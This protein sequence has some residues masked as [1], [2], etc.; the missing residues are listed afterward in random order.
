VTDSSQSASG[1]SRTDWG[2]VRRAGDPH[3]SRHGESL[4]SVA[5]RYW[6]VIY[7]FIRHSGRNDDEARELTQAFLAD[8]LLGRGLLAM[9]SPSRGRFR[10]L[11]LSA[12]ANFVRDDHRRRTAGHRPQASHRVPFAVP[13][14]MMA[15]AGA[16]PETAFTGAWVA[17]LVDEAATRL[18][19]EAQREGRDAHWLCFERRVLRPALDGTP[20]ASTEEL[21]VIT[22]IRTAARVAHA[23]ASMKRR[24]AM[25]L[26]ET[27]GSIGGEIDREREEVCELLSLLERRP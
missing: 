27:M 17:M 24:F 7:A 22:G 12:V 1:A 14:I 10:A 26:L 18:R 9:A 19:D 13:S 16:S 11:L 25:L 3:A 15:D 5:R 4:E 21:R 8:V 23:I 2:E 20:P 6:P